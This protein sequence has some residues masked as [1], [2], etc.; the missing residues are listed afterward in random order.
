MWW[1]D[2]EVPNTAPSIWTLGR[3]QLLSPEYLLSVE[4]WALPFRTTGSL[5][6]AFLLNCHSRSQAGPCHCTNLTTCPAYCWP[7]L[8]S[9]PPLLF[10]GDRPSQ[11]THQALS[12]IDSG[13]SVR[14]SKLQGVVFQGRLHAH[15]ATRFQVSRT[16]LHVGSMF[17]IEAVVKVH[18]VF[19]SLA[20]AVLHL[21]SD[22]NFTVSLD[23]NSVAIITPMHCGSELTRPEIS[24]TLGPL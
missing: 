19:P 11:T 12:V 14:T 24:F 2:I 22:F 3:Y 16:Y 4:R 20:R 6:P 23:W 9:A 8:P 18:G 1:A 13:T 10:G 15:L 21:H 7:T 17:G 5:W